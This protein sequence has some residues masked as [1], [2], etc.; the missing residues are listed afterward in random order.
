MKTWRGLI[1]KK[2]SKTLAFLTLGALF[3]QGCSITSSRKDKSKEKK[4][5]II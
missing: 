3:L 4:T 5:L 2:T 1:M